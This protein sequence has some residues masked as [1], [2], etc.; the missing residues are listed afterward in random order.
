MLLPGSGTPEAMWATVKY[1]FASQLRVFRGRSA[2]YGRWGGTEEDEF[3][4]R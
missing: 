3:D 4:H 1:S 2:D